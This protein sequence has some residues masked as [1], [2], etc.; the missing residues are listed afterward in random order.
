MSSC[1]CCMSAYMR[2]TAKRWCSRWRTT[3]RCLKATWTMSSKQQRCSELHTRYLTKSNTSN[4]RCHTTDIAL[5]LLIT[6]VFCMHQEARVS[7]AVELMS[8]H[9]EHLKRRHAI[10]SEEMLE[11]RKLLHRRKGRLHSDSTGQ[12]CP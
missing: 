5:S 1:R 7:N 12:C 9:V 10:E 4:Q 11:V 3:C 6:I 8:V 2:W